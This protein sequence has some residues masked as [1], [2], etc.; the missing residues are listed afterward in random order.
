MALT[1]S[2]WIHFS[3]K[4]CGLEYFLVQGYPACS[5]NDAKLG[6]GSH[7]LYLAMMGSGIVLQKDW[8]SMPI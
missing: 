4:N 2:S 5:S 7:S 1:I 3:R 6:T 8:S